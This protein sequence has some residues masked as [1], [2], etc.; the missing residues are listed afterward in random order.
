M[1]GSIT[2]KIDQTNGIGNGA[3]RKTFK[4]NKCNNET[5]TL[6]PKSFSREAADMNSYLF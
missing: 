5:V 1:D 2:T 6:D 4:K 3:N